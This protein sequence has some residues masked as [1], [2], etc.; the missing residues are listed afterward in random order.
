MMGELWRGSADREFVFKKGKYFVF[1]KKRFGAAGDA[2]CHGGRD[3]QWQVFE[4]ERKRKFSKVFQNFFR[5]RDAFYKR[6]MSAKQPLHEKV[7]LPQIN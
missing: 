7:L 3:V 4:K 2:E 1:Q 6:K 5:E